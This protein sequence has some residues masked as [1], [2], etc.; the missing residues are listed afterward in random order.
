MI[1]ITM[2]IVIMIIIIMIIVIMTIVVIDYLHNL[3]KLQFDYY[4]IIIV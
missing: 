4:L 3:P 2:I 1:I